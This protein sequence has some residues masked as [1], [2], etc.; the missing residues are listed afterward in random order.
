M[1]SCAPSPGIKPRP[2]TCC[3][4]PAGP[5]AKRLRQERQLDQCLSRLLELLQPAA[6]R[7]DP[8]GLAALSA[9]QAA[10]VAAR[11]AP[12]A[13]QQLEA[14]VTTYCAL[15]SRCGLAR[16]AHCA[17]GAAGSFRSMGFCTKLGAAQCAVPAALPG[18]GLAMSHAASKSPALLPLPQDAA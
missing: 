2:D 13:R 7:E 11:L 18:P 9:K 14:D 3:C 10:R 12:Q 4:L 17:A 16:T 6:A 8:A 15:C 5:Q 1:C